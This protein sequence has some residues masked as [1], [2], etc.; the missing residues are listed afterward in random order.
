MVNGRVEREHG[1]TTTPDAYADYDL[2]LNYLRG[3]PGLGDPLERTPESIAEDLNGG[4]LLPRFAER[5]YGAVVHQLPDGH[6]QVSP[7]ETAERRGGAREE[8]QR[9]ARPVRE[10]MGAERERILA[11]QASEWVK[12]MYRSS[13]KLSEQ[14]AQEFRT[15]WEL[16]GDWLPLEGSERL[17]GSE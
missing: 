10:W 9:R 1:A 6:W 13:M 3:G 14:F 12:D 16:P 17:E 11:G 5:V 4:Y 8:R 2:Y 15:F 7:D